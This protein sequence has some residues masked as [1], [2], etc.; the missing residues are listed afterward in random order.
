MRKLLLLALAINFGLS[1][2]AQEALLSNRP[3]DLLKF[4]TVLERELNYNRL[5][6]DLLK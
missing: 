3:V 4:T 1:M 2:N 6:T 5:T